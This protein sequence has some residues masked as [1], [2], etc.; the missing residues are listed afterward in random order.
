VPQSE[1]FRWR[2]ACFELVEEFATSGATDAA[3]FVA[4][5]QRYL[6]V[7]NSLSDAIRFR[8]DSTIYR[9]NG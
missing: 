2:D 3:S 8:T 6:V 1:I 4:D 7:S 5:G 9:F